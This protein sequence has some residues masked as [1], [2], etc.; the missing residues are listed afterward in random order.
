LECAVALLLDLSGSMW[1]E[2]AHL[3]GQIATLFG[4]ALC[5]IPQI[6]FAVYGYNSDNLDHN[7]EI[8][9]QKDGYTR[10]ERI[11]HWVFKDFHENWKSVRERIGAVDKEMYVSGGATGGCNCDHE[12]LLFTAHKI[13]ARKEKRKIIIVLADG[14]PSGVHG[15][16]NGKLLELLHKTVKRIRDAQIDL[17]AFGMQCDL[18]ERFYKPNVEIVHKL[19]DLDQKALRKLAHYLFFKTL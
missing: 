16:Y 8:R 3:A 18:V 19:E 2:R 7:D 13:A 1:F 15:T 9:A 10:T 11:N 17:F 14:I 4:E 6:P 5:R 12:T